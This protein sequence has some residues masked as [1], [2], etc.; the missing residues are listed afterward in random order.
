MTVGLDRTITALRATGRLEP[1]DNAL[2]S[3]ARE[4]AAQLQAAVFDDDESR[5]TRGVLIARYHAV[6]SHLLAR[7]DADTDTVAAL[8]RLFAG[9]D[10]PARS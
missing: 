4:A 10:D 2:V 9:V 6:L 3:L 1:V 7:P 8:D 5:Y